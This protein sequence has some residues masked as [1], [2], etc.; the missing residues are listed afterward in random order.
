MGTFQYV[1][2]SSHAD[3]TLTLAIASGKSTRAFI[4]PAHAFATEAEA[5][6]LYDET[7]MAGFSDIVVRKVCLPTSRPRPRLSAH[8]LRLL[9]GPPPAGY[10]H[11]ARVLSNARKRKQR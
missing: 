2:L 3:R 9:A 10:I 7:R 6:E 11:D 1:V 4:E 5:R 8:Q